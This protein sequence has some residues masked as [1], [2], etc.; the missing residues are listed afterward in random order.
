MG[1]K[2]LIRLLISLAI[3]GGIATVLHYTGSGGISE[4]TSSTT[5]KKV[6]T[7]FPINEVASI[8]ILEKDRSVTLTK[9]KATW[10][11][12][13][14]D[15]Y[16]ANAAPIN[17]LLLEL[18]DLNIVQ[19]VTIGRSQF[20]RL[21]LIG[22]DEAKSADE[23]ATILR[24]K[25][26]EGNE[27]DTIWLGKVYER[28]E[29]R[30]NPMGGG[31]ATTE[32]GRYIKPG[33]TNSVYL[34]GN[35]FGGAQA[36]AADWLSKDFFKAVDIRS[37]EIQTGEKANDWKLVREDPSGDLAFAKAGKDEL[38][39]QTKV[40]SMKSAF[41][42]SQFE[43]VFTAEEAKE[44]QAGKTAFKIATFDGF[45]YVVSVGEKNDLNE[46]PLTLKVSAKLQDKRKPGEDESD[47]DKERLNKEFETNLNELKTKLANEKKLEGKTFKIR[48]FLVDSITKARTDLLKEDEAALPKPGTEIA[49][50]VSIP[51]LPPGLLQGGGN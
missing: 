17:K 43:D 40:S 11:V 41:N 1:T 34:V 19:P 35:T 6:F 23:A 50:G 49:P 28:S 27:L 22:P 24:F 13:E 39:D 4:V 9:G 44:I 37:I 45:N 46:L 12:S 26:A 42:N 30:P 3:V 10:E 20:S 21:S 32:A 47:E 16:P 31:M 8:E 15:G 33:G 29:N 48:S 5:K 36:E 25:D 51:G 14:R 18:W 38:L 2:T 7:D